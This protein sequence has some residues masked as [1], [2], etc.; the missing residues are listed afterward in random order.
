MLKASIIIPMKNEE[1]NI[2]SC[3]ESI[4]DNSFSRRN[5]EII[6]VDNGSTD[7]TVELAEKY[8]T[9]I[10]CI[11]DKTISYL[12]NYG[13]QK[14]QGEYL[15][16]VDADCVVGK[17]WL[18]AASVYFDN[19]KIVCFGSTPEI[20]VDATWVEKAFHLN[21]TMK[22]DIQQVEWLPSANIIVKKDVFWEIGGFNESLETCEDVDLCYRIDQKYKIISDKKIK[23][24]HL[25]EPKT[26]KELFRKEL[27]RGK[28]NL[29]GLK[30]HGLKIKEIPSIVLP[31]YYLILP[32][33]FITLLCLKGVIF[34]VLSFMLLF[35]T[36]AFL[37]SIL[38]TFKARKYHYIL[39]TFAV[40][41]TY[42]VS[43]AVSLVL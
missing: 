26:I 14:A 33:I 15:A 3:L 19:E 34:A 24:V 27:W 37:V 11:P 12:R 20:P 35:F 40:Y 36:P 13:A 17:A 21:S 29:N 5:Y 43:R 42:F 38:V 16:F 9:S 10:Y 41:L 28:N 18:D 32:I 1:N 31:L 23:A 4:L 7:R 25:R 6:C 2:D 22:K 30:E 8:A 39:K